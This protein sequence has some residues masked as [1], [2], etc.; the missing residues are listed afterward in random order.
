MREK[1]H[2]VLE[3]ITR[4]LELFSVGW[5]GT[6]QA[7]STRSRHLS[8]FCDECPRGAAMPASIGISPGH[9][10]DLEFEWIAEAWGG[11]DCITVTYLFA[12][13]SFR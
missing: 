11:R 12:S 1:A 13:R 4:R 6:T 3:A 5:R 9:G 10:G 2:A 8:V 7:K